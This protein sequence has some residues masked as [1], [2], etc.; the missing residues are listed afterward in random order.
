MAQSASQPHS[1]CVEYVVANTQDHCPFLVSSVNGARYIDIK[2]DHLSPGVG[3]CLFVL[4]DKTFN[5]IFCCTRKLELNMLLER[6]EKTQ[7][8]FGST[9]LESK[10]VLPSIFTRLIPLMLV[11]LS[12]NVKHADSGVVPAVEW[13]ASVCGAARTNLRAGTMRKICK[14]PDIRQSTHCLELE[15]IRSEIQACRSVWA[16]SPPLVKCY[17]TGI[18]LWMWNFERHKKH[19]IQA[20]N[21]SS[22]ACHERVNYHTERIISLCSL[23]FKVSHLYC[24]NGAGCGIRSGKCRYHLGRKL[25]LF[26]L[27]HPPSSDGTDRYPFKAYPLDATSA[28]R[29]WGCWEQ[30]LAD[31]S[32]TL[33]RH[34]KWDID[35]TCVDTLKDLGSRVAKSV[36]LDALQHWVFEFERADQRSGVTERLKS[37]LATFLNKLTSR[38]L[39]A[40]LQHYV[41][42]VF[43]RFKQDALLR[44]QASFGNVIVSCSGLRGK[45]QQVYSTV[46]RLLRL[47]IVHE[48]TTMKYKLPR[49]AFF[50]LSTLNTFLPCAVDRIL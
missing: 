46:L 13:D 47:V 12:V 25:V 23:K 19:Y 39:D 11:M 15:V 33:Y 3:L 32:Q 29:L 40:I 31:V 18:G 6:D 16:D 4:A 22:A 17:C 26:I 10:L 48:I 20:S 44:S 1:L 7:K 43:E 42:P 21:F 34:G 28:G 36:F 27:A 37:L 5:F 50:F 9:R 2:N 45:R 38:C 30:E 14:W 24:T 8:D 41:Y 49:I 35:S